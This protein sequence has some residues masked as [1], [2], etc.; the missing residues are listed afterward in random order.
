MQN[1]TKAISAMGLASAL[2]LTGCS[3]PNSDLQAQLDSANSRITE[4]EAEVARKDSEITNLNTKIEAMTPQQSEAAT[5]TDSPAEDLPT[6]SSEQLSTTNVVNFD[7]L[8]IEF[9]QDCKIETVDNQFSEYNGTK[10]I[11]VPVS[12]TNISNE[13]NYLNMFYLKVYGSNG[14]QSDYLNNYFDDGQLVFSKLRPGA[15][16]DAYI[17]IPYDGDGDYYVS[18]EKIGQASIDQLIHIELS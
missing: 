16:V 2:M 15:S 8:Q 17:Y 12:I 9:T 18:F 5:S 4:L 10:T 6:E 3:S 14:V 13:T 11:G 1:I 7:G